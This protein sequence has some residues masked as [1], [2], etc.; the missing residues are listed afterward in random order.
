MEDAARPPPGTAVRHL[1]GEGARRPARKRGPRDRGPAPFNLAGNLIVPSQAT[2]AKVEVSI[3]SL[4][5]AARLAACIKSLSGACAGTSWRPTVVDNSPTGQD[6]TDVLASAPS[7]TV[8][9]SEG[10]RGFGANQNLALTEL[11]PHDRVRYV[12]I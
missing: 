8:I 7:P 6:L 4:G 12:L 10:R 5:D 11:L 1:R 9:R 2:P 3:V